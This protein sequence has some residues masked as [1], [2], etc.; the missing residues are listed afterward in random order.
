MHSRSRA[1]NKTGRLP[2]IIVI[3]AVIAAVVVGVYAESGDMIPVQETESTELAS[4]QDKEE[5]LNEEET[6]ETGTAP[7]ASEDETTVESSKPEEKKCTHPGWDEHFRC[8]KCGEPCKHDGEWRKGVCQI[9]DF[10]CMH[11][12][13]VVDGVCTRCGEPCPHYEF[14]NGV[15]VECGFVCEH[16]SHKQDQTCTVCHEKV[17]HRFINGECGICG[18]HY[19]AIDQSVSN[20]LW[21]LAPEQGIIESFSYPS[22]KYMLDGTFTDTTKR[23]SVYLPYGYSEDQQYDLLLLIP[24]TDMGE[25][26]ILGKEHYYDEF[27]QSVYLKN[28]LD[29]CIY[30]KL[31]K[32][33]IIVNITYYGDEYGEYPAFQ[34]DSNQVAKELRYDILP[35]LAERYPLYA[36]TS[37]LADLQ[38]AR[39]HVGIFGTSYGGMIINYKL[40][41]ECLDLIGWFAASSA[42]NTDLTE[43]IDAIN[44]NP[45]L[46]VCFYYCGSGD[47][48]RARN[49]SSDVYYNLITKCRSLVENYNACNAIISYC[50]HDSKAYDTGIYNCCRI[51]FTEVN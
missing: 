1:K 29:N 36:K 9:C 12:G 17:Y 49:Q 24:G 50:G 32:P 30:Q 6:E 2:V 26:S 20:Y 34:Q 18:Y 21:L 3:V 37:N 31:F 10:E 40:M 23:M 22:H 44:S 47:Q 4:E 15:C 14:K 11:E 7:D 45:Q 35:Y 48:D 51:F 33:M 43:T 38:A 19:T 5:V 13:L 16:P 42:F 25:M 41:H 46:P 27:A 39:E 28:L 8:I